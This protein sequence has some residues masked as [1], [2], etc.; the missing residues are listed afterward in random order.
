M[1]KLSTTAA[2]AE[3][4]SSW[5]TQCYPSKGAVFSKAEP[6]RRKAPSGGP[7][8]SGNCKSPSSTTVSGPWLQVGGQSLRVAR[9]GE[10]FALL[11]VAG[12]SHSSLCLLVWGSCIWTAV[13]VLICAITWPVLKPGFALSPWNSS[14]GK[15]QQRSTQH[16]YG[17]EA[18]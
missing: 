12:Q 14:T 8:S 16:T 15:T 9:S 4:P 5:E 11:E 6:E 1:P 7:L 10:D 2:S 17:W 13:T 3:F 18:N